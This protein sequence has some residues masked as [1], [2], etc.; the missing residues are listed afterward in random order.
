MINKTIGICTMERFDNR[1]L[2]SVGSSR[3]RARWLL[4][5]WEEAEEFIIGK[6]YEALIF[7]KVYWDK[8]MKEYKGIKILDLCDPDWL[9]GKPVLE[10]ADYADAV[11]TS[12]P[13]LAEYI[14]KFRP[15]MLIRCIPDRIYLPEHL[16]RKVEHK[17]NAK[18]AVW[19]GYG[20]N[21]HYL[22][23]A[24]DEIINHGLE[25]TI[26]SNTPY[27]APLGYQN[28][29]VK[30]VAYTYPGVHK[31]IIN[32]DIVIMPDPEGDEKARFKSNN[33]TLQCWALGM[34][35]AKTADDLDRFVDPAERN[36]EAKVRLKEIKERWDVK[37]SVD[38]MKALIEEIKIKR[39]GAKK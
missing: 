6:D 32:A 23:Q 22:Q 19:F 38:E 33:K 5:Y 18:K 37:I 15:E 31:E 24:F 8:M 29:N 4:Q 20:Q 2:N 21:I 16:P 3:I 7:Q 14:K 27:D 30:N 36:K 12:T 25:L 39:G 10:Y 9:E 34:P 35:V 17:G 28:L 11:T 26:V 1:R 13:A